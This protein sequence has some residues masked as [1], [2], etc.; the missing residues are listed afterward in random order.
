M[1]TPIL[2]AGRSEDRP[3]H[4]FTVAGVVVLVAALGAQSRTSDASGDWPMYS[5]SLSGQRY[6]PL[7]DITPANVTRLSP[8]WSLRLTQPAAARRGGGPP[9][10]GEGAPGRGAAPPAANP[11]ADTETVNAASRSGFRP[12]F[13]YAS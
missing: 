8:A 4:W 2:R 13:P 1:E 6:S 3:L 10:A 11:P 9:A 7:A 5:H 12:L